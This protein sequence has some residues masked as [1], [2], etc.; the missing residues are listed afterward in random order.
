MANLV[1]NIKQ[2]NCLRDDIIQELTCPICSELATNPVRLKIT[3]DQKQ[4][5]CNDV[6]CEICI[7]KMF[8]HYQHSENT[9]ENIKCPICSQ[10][11]FTNNVQCVSECYVEDKISKKIIYNLLKETP[12]LHD[13][14]CKYNC[15]FKGKDVSDIDSHYKGNPLECNKR[16][17]KCSTANCPYIDIIGKSLFD[18][19]KKCPYKYHMCPFCTEYIENSKTHFINHVKNYH[20]LKTIEVFVSLLDNTNLN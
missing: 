3:E 17:V 7:I 16:I 19:E 14:V 10:K 9:R 15:G 18:H 12:E 11:I 5:I 6:F 20:K 13:Y 1:T 4:T 8:Y 2:A